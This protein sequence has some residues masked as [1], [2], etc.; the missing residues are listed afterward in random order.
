M[1]LSPA[2]AP[3]IALSTLLFAATGFAECPSK[4]DLLKGGIRFQVSPTGARETH[5]QV[6]DGMTEVL[7]RFADG[8]GNKMRYAHGV[9]ATSSKS[10][11]GVEGSTFASA[12]DYRRWPAPKPKTRIRLPN[13]RGDI[14]VTTG[15]ITSI[16]W[17]TC[18]FKMFEVAQTFPDEPGVKETYQYLPELGIGLAHRFQNGSGEDVYTYKLVAQ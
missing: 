2:Y 16:K 13:A 14:Q 12:E 7:I 4:S 10:L 6:A 17:G 18:T 15:A 11:K 1:R 8:T 5:I 3:I 9:Y